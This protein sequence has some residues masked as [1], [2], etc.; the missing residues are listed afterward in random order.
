MHLMLQQHHDYEFYVQF[1]EIYK[2]YVLQGSVCIGH[3]IWSYSY[4]CI[5]TKNVNM[6][7]K[8]GM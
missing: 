3:N 5:I 4:Y 7:R 1:V 8:V 6:L 2:L